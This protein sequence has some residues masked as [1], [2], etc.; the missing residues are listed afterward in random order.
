M[1][2]TL[3]RSPAHI[4]AQAAAGLPRWA[5]VCLSLAFIVPGLFGH[6]LW[7]QDAAG[8]GRMWSMAQGTAIDWL[9]PNVAGT[10]TPQVGPLPS[11]VG[12]VMILLFGKYIGDTQAAA[13]SN[14]LWYPLIV[15]ALW[16]AVYRLARRDEAQ[17]VAAAF[18]GEASRHDYARLLA[19]ISVLLTIGTLGVIWRLHQTRADSASVACVAVAMLA[20]SLIEWHLEFAALLAGCAVG[21]FALTQGPVPAAGLLLGCLCAFWRARADANV[22]AVRLMA[23]CGL[24]LFVTIALAASWPLAAFHW[25]PTEAE[26]FFSSWSLS[27]PFGWPSAEDAA[28]LVRDGS[29]FFWPLWPLAFWAVYAWRSSL[30]DAHIQRPLLLLI[31]L[32]LAMFFSAPLDELAAVGI[33][34]PLVALAAYGATTLR[35]ALDNVI[36][37][38]AIALF[39]LALFML[40][41][42]FI[43]M[44]LGVPKAMAASI[45]RLTPGYTD[46]V[47][48]VALVLAAVATVAWLQLIAWRIVRRPPVLWRGPLLAAFGVTV[49]WIA[50]N[51]LYL[52]AVDYVFS[53]HKFAVELGAQLRARGLGKGCVQ[54]HRIPLPERAIIAYYG[55]IRFDREGASESCALALHRDS[56]RSSLD[57]DPPPGVHGMWALS[58]EGQRKVRPDERWRIWARN[59]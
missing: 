25:F 27:I 30:R 23:A 41:A 22:S 14:L 1:T 29:W 15:A 32:A 45:A 34:P 11:W 52:P 21:S 7:P 59:D 6:N 26:Q 55:K 43:A 31:G 19:D 24:L 33:L 16:T 40:W 56:K 37:W 3:H 49:V 18:G 36:D 5:L 17:P 13:A 57:E 12:A 28:W 9:L 44:E 10:P 4:S 46:H 47:H 48:V 51:L 42:Y 50:A 2:E 53:Y 39:S 20:T 38:L 58:W 8:F 35:R 54:A